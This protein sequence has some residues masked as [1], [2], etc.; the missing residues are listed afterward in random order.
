MRVCSGLR[1]YFSFTPSAASKAYVKYQGIVKEHEK[2]WETLFPKKAGAELRFFPEENIVEHDLSYSLGI[3]WDLIGRK[4]KAIRPILITQLGDVFGLDRRISLPVAY[5]V[6]TV[7]NCTLVIDDIEDNS[8]YRRGDKCV[9]L[10]YGVDNSINAGCLGYFLPM[11][12]LLHHFKESDFKI[13]SESLL[14]ISQI[15]LDE[16]K[17]IHL[18][19]AWDIGWHSKHH[20]TASLP[21]TADYLRM[22]ESK[23]SVLIRIG[24]RM[25]AELAK[26]NSQDANSVVHLANKAGASFQIRDDLINLTEGDYRGKGSGIGDDITEGKITLMVIEHVRRTGDQTLLDLLANKTKD[27]KAITAA[28]KTMKDSGALDYSDHFQRELMTQAR[29]YLRSLQG[30]EVA[31]SEMDEVLAELLER[32]K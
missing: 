3:V 9:H 32:K 26:A 31:K 8:E 10:K 25:I 22:V 7:H 17:N 1:R 29:Q 2:T 24:F 27:Q 12:N 13:S 16:M 30:S 28:I 21:T 23:T 20:K 15:Y 5:L 14:A 11:S 18:G 4:G 6:E 19:L